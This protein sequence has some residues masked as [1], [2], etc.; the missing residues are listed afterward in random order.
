MQHFPVHLNLKNKI[1]VIVGGGRIAQRKLLNL[2]GTG[3]DITVVSPEV[4]DR[5]KNEVEAG[6]VNWK[7]KLFSSDD[8]SGAFLVI[9]ATNV[10]EINKGV[11]EAC[12]P[13]QLVSLVDDPERS[14]FIVPGAIH[15]GKL[16]MSVSTSGASPGLSK[17]IVKEISDQFDDSYEDYVEFLS[18][19]RQRVL[20]EVEDQS[21][22]Q[23]IF[24]SLLEPSFL[25]MTR[26]HD[27]VGRES[28]FERLLGDNK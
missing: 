8:V 16:V 22:R 2:L 19:C 4:V 13:G 27:K 6:R 15:R 12:A 17:K 21:K 18:Q 20:R 26:E 11:F 28:A 5:I 24:Q 7:Q 23:Q 9:A 10:K 1:V 3:A 14:N 25:E